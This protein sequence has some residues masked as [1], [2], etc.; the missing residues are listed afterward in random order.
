MKIL[1]A[2]VVI[3]S[4]HGDNI[5]LTTDLPSPFSCDEGTDTPL[6]LSFD[7]SRNKG[8]EYVK[9]HFDIEPKIITVS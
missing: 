7:C 1:S 6:Y 8:I 4:G 5:S 9:K 2:S 3:Q